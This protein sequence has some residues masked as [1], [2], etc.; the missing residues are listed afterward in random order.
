M[1]VEDHPLYSEWDKALNRL[2]EAERRYHL[3]K[4]EGQSEDDLEPA[5]RELDEARE[6]YLAMSDQIEMYD[7]PGG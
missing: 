5:G 6:A 3:G 1:A 2:I 7:A 4:F